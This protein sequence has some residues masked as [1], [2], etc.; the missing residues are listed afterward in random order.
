[1]LDEL[2]KQHHVV[3]TKTESLH[4]VCKK[5]LSEQN[6]LDKIVLEISIPLKIL[7]EL[8]EIGPLVVYH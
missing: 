5:L 6:K 3:S 8:D 1:M 2:E 4:E 7:Q